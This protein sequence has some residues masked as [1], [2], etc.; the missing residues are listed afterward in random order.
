MKKVL[1]IILLSI[2]GFNAK[3]HNFSAV[4]NGD[5]IYYKIISSVSPY[6]AI[7]TYKGGSDSE[8]LDEYSGDISIPDSVTYYNITYRVTA[9]DY[10]AFRNCSNL[11]SI[12]I[13][14]SISTIQ[15]LAFSYCTSLSSVIIPT[16]ITGIGGGAFSFCSSLDTVFFNAVNCL[17]I[18]DHPGTYFLGSNNIT[19]IIFGDSVQSIAER[20]FNYSPSL[21]NIVFSNSI[22]SIADYAFSSCNTLTAITIPKSIQSVGIHAFS[23]CS[24]LDTI[25][26]NAVNCNSLG[27]YRYSSFTGSNNISTIVIGDSVESIPNHAFK[28]RS[29]VNSIICYPT[30][31]PTIQG[32]TL[33]GI[34]TVVPIRVYCNSMA[35]YRSAPYWYYYSIFRSIDNLGYT[36]DATICQGSVYSE[37]GFYAD[38]SG[39]YIQNLRTINGC[40][41]TINL[42]LSIIPIIQSPANL[43]IESR[44]NYFEILF[45]GNANTYKIYRND[46][47]LTTT[48]QTTFI[49]S[50]LTNAQEYCYKIKAITGDCE[51]E[52][53]EAVCK[54]FIGLN[55]VANNESRVLIYPNPAKDK[56]SLKIEAVE[57]EVEIIIIDIMGRVVKEYK[58]NNQKPKLELDLRGLAKGIYNLNIRNN[59]NINTSKKLIVQ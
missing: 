33:L 45:E 4:Y 10:Y 41:S 50:N 44:P 28:N 52:F 1:F 43:S 12:N 57:Q 46:E 25:F 32:Q 42:N 55:D 54:N 24:S 20:A 31:P 23:Y 56:A 58:A 8:Y 2:L 21:R 9:I 35:D 19:T 27:D 49:D 16:S 6:T 51:S 40:D 22:I 11:T 14:N 48:N 17:N 47:Y 5:T 7:V 13:P 34:S 36:I 38:S 3:A 29:S 26:Y 53:S 30:N 59:K 39:H 18:G 15:E 37:N